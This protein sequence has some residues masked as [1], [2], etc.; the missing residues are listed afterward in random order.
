GSSTD[1]IYR[2]E[3]DSLDWWQD[4]KR[5]WRA[6]RWS[7]VL[8]AVLLV[9]GLVIYF[10]MIDMKV[11]APILTKSHDG[12]QLIDE[13]RTVVSETPGNDVVALDGDVIL[14]IGGV[15]YHEGQYHVTKEPEQTDTAKPINASK[16]DFIEIVP[17]PNLG[18]STISESSDN[19]D[20]SLFTSRTNVPVSNGISTTEEPVD[21]SAVES[22]GFSPSFDS[23]FFYP[24]SK[25]FNK[26]SAGSEKVSNEENSNDTDSGTA[27][28]LIKKGDTTRNRITGKDSGKNQDASGRNPVYPTLP[29][30]TS[31]IH[32]V[33]EVIYHNDSESLCFSPHLTMCRGTIPYDLTTLPLVQ[34]I[35]KLADL[36]AALPYFEMIVESGCS[37]RARQFVCPLLE[38]ECRPE[39][40][41]ILPPCR[42]AC[43]AVAEE[44][45]DFI[46]ATLDLSQVFNCEQYPDSDDPDICVNWARGD[47]CL[48]QEF[49]CPGGICIPRRWQCDGVSDCPYAADE[50]NCTHCL[51][52]EFRCENDNRCIPVNWHCDGSRDCPDGSDE[53]NCPKVE[54][55]GREQFKCEDGSAC[56]SARWICDGVNHCRDN[57]DEKNCTSIE[58]HAEHFKCQDTGYCIPSMW[59]CNG[60]IDCNDSS[61]EQGCK[62]SNTNAQLTG[63][64]HTSPCPVGELRCLD[65]ICITV[66]Q[67]CDGKQDCSDGADEFNCGAS[68]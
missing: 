13:F 21:G 50:N 35:N 10:L 17:A 26:A 18:T 44:C 38:P 63:T 32:D 60:I 20:S 48:D 6:L 19:F 66:Q 37:E 23:G 1:T 68:A 55:C 51:S 34:G 49:Q 28:P 40:D 36:D 25:F 43:K 54:E 2:T 3:S 5:G 29:S 53:Q 24:T 39:G 4:K 47:S 22:D 8:L 45:K 12:E 57:S 15:T 31:V 67:L 16:Q 65:G 62:H 11:M 58:C 41:A 30:S 61:D 52:E 33:S 56:I 64:P 7:L 59:R 46:L 42:K 14:D 9:V 27:L